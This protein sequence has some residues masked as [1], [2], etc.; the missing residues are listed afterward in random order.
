MILDANI[1]IISQLKTEIFIKSLD[2]VFNLAVEA[3]RFVAI[4]LCQI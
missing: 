1:F 3:F 2:I 4:N